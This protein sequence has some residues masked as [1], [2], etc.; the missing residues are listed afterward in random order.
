MEHILEVKGLSFKYEEQVVFRNIDIDVFRGDFLAFVGPNGSGKSTL[1]KLMV[2]DLQPDNGEVKLF[3]KRIKYFKE[4]SRIGY[5]SQ[6][7]REFNHSFPATVREI[8]AANLYHQMGIIKIITGNLEKKIDKALRLVDMYEYKNRK[9]GNLS[10][11]QQQRVFIA[12]TLVTEPE[13]IFLDEP[14]VGI[15]AGS[16]DEF[17]KLINRLNRKL[18][19]TILMV[20]HDIHVISSQ[21]NKIACFG[22]DKIHLHHADEFDYSSYFEETVGESRLLPDHSHMIKDNSATSGSSNHN[23]RDNENTPYQNNLEQ[24]SSSHVNN[25]ESDSYA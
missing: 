4:W 15:D 12:R 3:G 18:N 2:G 6:Q 23:C 17:I 16:Q 22:K 9:I 11:G 7:V 21:A 25:Q 5:M 24:E 19:I 8:V 14:M 20:S 13:I 1:M 10:G